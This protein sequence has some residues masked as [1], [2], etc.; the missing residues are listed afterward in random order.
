MSSV[1]KGCAVQAAVQTGGKEEESFGPSAGLH[2]RADREILGPPQQVTCT[3]QASGNRPP[4][5]SEIS[6]TSSG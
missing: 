2:C 4:D 3:H 6:P 1:P 5:S